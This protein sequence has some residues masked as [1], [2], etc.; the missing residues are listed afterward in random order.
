MDDFPLPPLHGLWLCCLFKNMSCP[1][2]STFGPRHGWWGCHP[3]AQNHQSTHLR[4]RAL[5]YTWN[6]STRGPSQSFGGKNKV[7]HVFF[8]PEWIVPRLIFPSW[9]ASLRPCPLVHSCNGLASDLCND[10]LWG[11][12]KNKMVS[13]STTQKYVSWTKFPKINWREINRA[14]LPCLSS[15]I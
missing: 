1:K 5:S 15:K 12:T 7:A 11:V 6:F 8:S 13:K 14:E 10:R 2:P 9:S 3:G 4:Y